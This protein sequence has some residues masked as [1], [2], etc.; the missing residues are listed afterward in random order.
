MNRLNKATAAIFLGAV[1]ANAIAAQ[2]ADTIVLKLQPGRHG[3]GSYMDRRFE[4]QFRPAV[5]IDASNLNVDVPLYPG[6]VATDVGQGDAYGGFGLEVY[7]KSAS[8]VYEI[9]TDDSSAVE[10]YRKAFTD[11]GYSLVDLR[12]I[13]PDLSSWHKTFPTERCYFYDSEGPIARRVYTMDFD[14]RKNQA[15]RVKVHVNL[16][17]AGSKK[18]LA[19]Y[20]ATAIT[21]PSRPSQSLVPSTIKRIVL[22]HNSDSGEFQVKSTSTITDPQHILDV[23]KTFNSLPVDGRGTHGNLMASHHWDVAFIDAD[24]SVRTATAIPWQFSAFID[25]VPLFDPN[26][27]MDKLLTEFSSSK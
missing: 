6:A 21:V 10:W 16:R 5:A 7:L 26:Q 18:T 24:G 11:A 19:T 12:S 9:P 14:S 15:E 22:V 27:D 1:A 3:F 8:A 13:T 2:A 17:S 20:I 4:S 25:K 23:V